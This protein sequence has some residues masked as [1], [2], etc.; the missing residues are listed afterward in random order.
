M[1]G[2]RAN[3]AEISRVEDGRGSLRFPSPLIK[4]DVLISSIRL[5]DWHHRVDP[6]RASVVRA[7][8][9][10]DREFSK[11]IAKEEPRGAAPVVSPAQEVLHPVID[12]GVNGPVGRLHAFHG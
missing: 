7:H 8:K 3:E 12:M 1:I 2:R 4:P 10:R 9:M 11:H 6:R 5:S